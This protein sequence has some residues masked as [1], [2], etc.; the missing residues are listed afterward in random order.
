[1]NLSY[2]KKLTGISNGKIPVKDVKKKI[3]I[4][5]FK[6]SSLYLH[7]FSSQSET[8]ELMNKISITKE[9]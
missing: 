6:K 5:F 9:K 4:F 7:I 8:L 1:M 3:K 2:L